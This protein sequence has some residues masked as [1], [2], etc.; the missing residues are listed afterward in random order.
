MRDFDKLSELGEE[1]FNATCSEIFGEG[2]KDLTATKDDINANIGQLQN[3][4]GFNGDLMER[5]GQ[6]IRE[7][8]EI[9]IQVN[10]EMLDWDWR[11]DED[12]DWEIESPEV[13]TVTYHPQE[14][15]LPF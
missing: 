13:P 11:D 4:L 10:E 7:R 12:W 3:Q 6:I 8:R 15:E 2:F 1:I 14:G 5:P 9:P